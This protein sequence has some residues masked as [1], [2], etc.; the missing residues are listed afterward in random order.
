VGKQFH[1]VPEDGT[2][3]HRDQRFGSKLS[4]FPQSGALTAAQYYNFHRI[5]KHAFWWSFEDL[6]YDKFGS[7]RP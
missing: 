5:F 3:A 7:S 6:N 2:L 4:F 1:N